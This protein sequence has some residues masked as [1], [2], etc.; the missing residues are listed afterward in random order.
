MPRPGEDVDAVV[1][2]RS[3]DRAVQPSDMTKSAA[4][5]G[6][7][8]AEEERCGVGAV[9]VPNSAGDLIS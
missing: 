1:Y 5:G 7:T 6:K 2:K 9:L 4:F 3:R 8:G